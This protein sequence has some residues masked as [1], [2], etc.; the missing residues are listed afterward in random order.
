[1]VENPGDFAGEHP[2]AMTPA[3]ISS[4]LLDLR[5]LVLEQDVESFSNFEAWAEIVRRN[6]ANLLI[7]SE[8]AWPNTAS[9]PSIGP[10]KSGE[11]GDD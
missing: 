11:P 4:I 5:T 9:S 1:M 8:S 7:D 6:V 2:F 10:D 3:E